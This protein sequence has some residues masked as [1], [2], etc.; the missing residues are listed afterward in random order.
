[1][2]MTHEH[3]VTCKLLFNLEYVLYN[4]AMCHNLN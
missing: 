1:M 2:N 4:L 3:K